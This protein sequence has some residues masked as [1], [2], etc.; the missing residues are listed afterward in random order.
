MHR[1]GSPWKIAVKCGL[2]H[3][4]HIFKS[5]FFLNVRT[6]TTSSGARS[7]FFSPVHRCW[8]AWWLQWFDI[9]DEKKK[10]P[11]LSLL[12][13]G[14]CRKQFNV[15]SHRMIFVWARFR[16]TNYPAIH[17]NVGNAL[18]TPHAARGNATET[19]FPFNRCVC[20]TIYN[21]KIVANIC[22][23]QIGF[24]YFRF[25]KRQL[26]CLGFCCNTYSRAHVRIYVR[27]RSTSPCPTNLH[28]NVHNI[29]RRRSI[30]LVPF[31]SGIEM[32]SAQYVAFED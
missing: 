29:C 30:T 27:V 23:I 12:T 31:L 14:V 10:Y 13:M 7:V 1:L 26:H 3:C 19:T 2:V 32:Y 8:S 20:P 15:L 28:C 4:E 24:T 9:E 21:S 6:R 11:A 18:P 5:V 16:S 25:G 22:L 17:T